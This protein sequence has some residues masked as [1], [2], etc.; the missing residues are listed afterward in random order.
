M[1]SLLASFAVCLVAFACH[2]PAEDGGA[3]KADIVA[4]DLSSLEMTVRFYAAELREA[5]Q[6]WS[7][8]VDSEPPYIDRIPAD[9]WGNEYYLESYADS[10]QVTLG[11]YGR[12]GEPGGT[13]EDADTE[14]VVRTG[15]SIWDR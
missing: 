10:K 6:T 12:D 9:P 15:Q 11:C 2:A 14:V 4:A 8:L 3:S 5:P 1:K 13:G 7:D